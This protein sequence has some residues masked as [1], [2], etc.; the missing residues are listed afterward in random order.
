[1]SVGFV[2]TLA[3]R[4]TLRLSIGNTQALVDRASSEVSSGRHYDVGLALGRNIGRALDLRQISG[5]IETLRSTN[6][7][8]TSRLQ[9]T[10]EALS[11]LSELADGL[12]SSATNAIGGG[13][14]RSLFVEDARSKLQTLNALLATTE[15]G[16][17]LFS[18]TNSSLAPLSDYL[19]SPSGAARTA[20]VGAFSSAFG[21]APDDPRTAAIAPADL[22][23]YLDGPFAGLL[24][25]PQ[26][27]TTFSFADDQP[28]RLRIAQSEVIEASVSANAS[29]IRRLVGA[30]VAV[31]DTGTENLDGASFA[32]LV[33]R[34]A[35]S[36]ATAATELADSRSQI[37]I[38]QER[39]ATAND[40]L[41]VQARLIEKG[42]GRL[43]GVDATEATTN[44]MQL[45][46]RL[47]TTY[48]MTARLQK[49]SLL[50]Y[51]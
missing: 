11:G 30:L 31:I 8:A 14:K 13:I 43:E 28:V 20:V 3:A 46:T 27:S 21:F 40:R 12:F 35:E 10:Q 50:A 32:L 23:K 7:I 33:A 9:S 29:G 4:E 2:S 36:A 44:L 25:D 15:G 37:G 18:G 47:E 38:A 34:V 22:A 6:A 1:M 17:H 45:T 49:L 41:A 48:A 42:I 19:A 5:E 26:W 39:I 16:A 24:A 51:L